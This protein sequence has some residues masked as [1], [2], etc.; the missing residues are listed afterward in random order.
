[1]TRYDGYFT[2]H[3]PYL[4]DMKASSPRMHQTDLT[5]WLL[6]PSCPILTWRD[7]YFTQNAHTE[8]TWWLLYPECN[9][10]N[11][12][13]DYFTQHAPYWSDMK[14]TLP[15]MHQTDLTWWLLYP[16]CTILNWH[17]DYFTRHAPYWTDMKA[18]LPRMPQT[19]LTWWL[20]YPEC[21]RLTWHG[22][23]AGSWS[24]SSSWPSDQTVAS[25]HCQP[26]QASSG[27]TTMIQQ[28][29]KNLI[30]LKW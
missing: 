10:L 28:A 16:E 22:P 30:V 4:T 7:G 13:D 23:E 1:M 21:S 6:Y 9:I 25:S 20:L 29:L 8:L 15:R 11:W 5:W 18:T 14:A 17:D 3:A 27:P 2:Q 24:S 12:H 26:T 19:D